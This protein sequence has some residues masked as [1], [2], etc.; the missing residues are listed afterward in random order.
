MSNSID[1][2]LKGLMNL[3][4][5]SKI[6]NFV[7]ENINK[8][9][10]V[11][12][13]GTGILENKSN[14]RFISILMGVLLALIM[15]SLLSYYLFYVLFFFSTL[16]CILWLFECY[17]PERDSVDK[18]DDGQYVG[19]ESASDILEYYIVLIFMLVMY[20]LTYIPIPIL[21]QIVYAI[22]IMLG[23]ASLSNKLY[24]RK[25]CLFL[26]DMFVN[27][28]CWKDGMYIKGHEGEMHKFLQTL[29]YAI[30]C[31]NLSSYNITHN[32]RSVYAKIE[33]PTTLRN[34]VDTV[35]QNPCKK[36]TE[37]K[38][39]H[40]AILSD[41]EDELD[42]DELDED[43]FDEDEDELDEDFN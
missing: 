35:L 2:G 41:N 10:T 33:G 16:K 1:S 17:N 18:Q 29:C 14:V 30:E 23:I 37:N 28:E 11:F 8:R 39:E 40:D 24:R 34:W 43:E 21:P 22:S 13:S 7:H 5:K 4:Q 20:P 27:K 19:E 31:I 36:I 6:L 26:R 12:F 9:I 32:P 42:G 15:F 25:I 3:V 38:K